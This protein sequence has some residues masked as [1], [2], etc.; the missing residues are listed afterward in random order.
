MGIYAARFYS[1][2][3]KLYLTL[4][5]QHTEWSSCGGVFLKEIRLNSLSPPLPTASIHD[6]KKEICKKHENGL[7]RRVLNLSDLILLK[8]RHRDL[9]VNISASNNLACRSM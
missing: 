4:P 5:W 8:V 9:Y 1:P 3:S 7:R 2:T 6:L